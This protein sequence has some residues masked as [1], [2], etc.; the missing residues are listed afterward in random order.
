MSGGGDMAGGRITPPPAAASTKVWDPFVRIFHWSLV[1]GFAFAFLTGDEWQS[2]HE[3]AGYVIASLVG[4]R[5][6]WGFIGTR[7]ARFS[8]FVRPPRAVIGFIGDTM[9]FRA[10]R[11]LGHNPAGGA[12]VVALLLAIAT[13][14]LTG[15]MMTTDAYWG[16]GWVEELHELAAYSTIGLIVLHVVGVVVASIEHRENLVRAMVTGRKRP[17]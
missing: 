9:H 7:H 6:V 4:L 17:L 5:V 8:D 2:A 12:M 15:W 16:V 3:L 14:C 1:G 11:Y 10:R 13:I